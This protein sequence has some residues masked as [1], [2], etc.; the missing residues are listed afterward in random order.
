SVTAASSSRPSSSSAACRSRATNAKRCSSNA[1]G[2]GV[3]AAPDEQ[4]VSADDSVT[5]GGIM[6]RRKGAKLGG[7]LRDRGEETVQGGLGDEGVEEATAQSEERLESTHAREDEAI[8]GGGVLDRAERA[9]HVAEPRDRIVD[10]LPLAA[11]EYAG[12]H[13]PEIGLGFVGA[14]PLSQRAPVHERREG[15]ARRSGADVEAFADFGLRQRDGREK[16]EP[17]DPPLRAREAPEGRD[18]PEDLRQLLLGE[19]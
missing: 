17:V 13:L 9:K 6:L 16:N 1:A 3:L 15:H 5:N 19:R 11:T 14:T 2:V 7:L 8:G 12:D 10:L 4:G 18:V